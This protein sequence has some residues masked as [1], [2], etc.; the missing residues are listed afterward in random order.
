MQ[1][2]ARLDRVKPSDHGHQLIIDF[3][4]A[5][6][7]RMRR[8]GIPVGEDDFRGLHI[9]EAEVDRLLGSFATAND[10]TDADHNALVA[11]LAAYPAEASERFARLVEHFALGTF[12]AGCLLLCLVVEDDLGAE[13]LIAYVQDDV[14]KRRPRVDLA[15]RLFAPGDEGDSWAAAFHPSWPLVRWKLIQVFDEPGQPFTP[16]RARYLALHPGVAMYLRGAA[17]IDESLFPFAELVEHGEALTLR[18]ARAELDEAIA[19]KLSAFPIASLDTRVIAVSGKDSSQQEASA[20]A[21]AAGSNRPLIT[22][23]LQELGAQLGLDAAM[24]VVLREAGLRDAVAFLG[25][26]GALTNEQWAWLMTTLRQSSPAPLVVIATTPERPPWTGLTVAI[27]AGTFEGRRATWLRELGEA[28]SVSDDELDVLADTFDLSATRIAEAARIAA[29]TA[30]WNSPTEAIPVTE[31]VFAAARVAASPVLLSFARRITPRYHWNDI[32]LPGDTRAQLVEL[33]GRARYARTVLDT[34][35]FGAKRVGRGA[36]ALFA[37]P[38]G[39][40][41]TMAAEIMAREL[42]LELYAIDLSGVVSKYIGETE[43]NLE[44]IF[45]EASAASALLFFDEADA[46]FGK[47]SEVKDAHDRYANIETAYLLQRIE[48][49]PGPVILA[50][51]LKLNLDEAFLRRLDFAIDFPFPEEAERT[52]IW[53][54]AFP[55]ATPIDPAVDFGFLANQF[56]LTGGNIRNIALAA[57]FMAAADDS[58]I[59]MRHLMAATRREYQ[60]LGRMISESDFGVHTGGRIPNENGR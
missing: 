56:R 13:R 49:Y 58:A 19:A 43:K 59:E 44:T 53:T 41:K 15:A 24:T 50:T 60:K 3:L 28:K 16:L 14:S 10:D 45:T 40:G 32:I 1:G 6:I 52:L 39:T 55:A 46:L 35:G 21:L 29:G 17:A 20:A 12:E 2:I 4:R 27:P 48:A 33:T 5:E 38:S 7:A 31:D 34:W 25:N 18:I 36:T 9:P 51:N 54:R 22:V 23:D 42:Q 47:R 30:L 11:R 37:G 8:G 57:A 26:T